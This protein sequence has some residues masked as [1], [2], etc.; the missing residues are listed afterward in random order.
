MT[1]NNIEITGTP[2]T[3][4]SSPNANVIMVFEI[5]GIIIKEELEIAVKKIAE[6]QILL[7]AKVTIDDSGKAYYTFSNH[8]APEI[9]INTYSNPIE[10]VLSEFKKPLIPDKGELIRFHLIYNTCS[11]NLIINCNQIICDGFSIYYLIED[12]LTNLSSSKKKEINSNSLVSINKSK[13][14]VN[15]GNTLGKL[16]I[17]KTNK[18]W[19]NK[20]IILTRNIYNSMYKQFW[21]K[22]QPDLI[23][24]KLDKNETG[25][26][27]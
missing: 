19:K 25:N 17:N 10:A 6:S 27:I 21:A 22:Q 3:F 23:V 7:K 9:T 24:S 20:H 1:T 4:V 2:R 5:K 26:L 13:I 15:P 11:T 18:E 12:I 16:L 14:P 8:Y